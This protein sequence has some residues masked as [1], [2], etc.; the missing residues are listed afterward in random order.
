MCA[1]AGVGEGGR[2][3]EEWYA[4]PY[5]ERVAALADGWREELGIDDFTARILREG[6]RDP[7]QNPEWGKGEMPVIPQTQ[8]E[9]EFGNE[10]V[11]KG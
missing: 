10:A 8:E 1:S 4:R 7:P 3:R 5:Y 6:I 9:K 11:E 2:T